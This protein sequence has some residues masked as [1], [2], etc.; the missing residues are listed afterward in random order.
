MIARL[1][2]VTMHGT[3]S[4]TQLS[5]TTPAIRNQADS[6]RKVLIQDYADVDSGLVWAVV[7]TKLPIPI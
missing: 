5:E 3:F 6:F 7:E 1:P 2:E 4:G